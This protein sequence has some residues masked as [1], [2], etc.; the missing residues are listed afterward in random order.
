MARKGKKEVKAKRWLDRIDLISLK[1]QSTSHH[2][3]LFEFEIFALVK[4]IRFQ[5]KVY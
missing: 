5:E 4:Q 3:F 2:P 1:A